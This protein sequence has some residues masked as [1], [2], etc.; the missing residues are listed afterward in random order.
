MTF[1][2]NKQILRVNLSRR[3][4]RIEKPSNFFYRRYF[5]GRAVIAYYLLK[6][7]RLGIDP[8]G[9]RNILVF[10][11]GVVTGA[12]IP[13]GGRNS[14]GAK[15]PLTGAY[16]EAEAGGFWGAELKHAGL[17]G[18]VIKGRAKSPVY[19]WI[20]D[21]EV[22]I[23][24]AQHLW[25]LDIGDSQEIIR[26]DAGERLART[27]QIGKGGE[28]MV[29]FACIINDLKHA[30]GRVGMGAVMG[31]KNLKAIAVRGHGGPE[32]ANVGKLKELTEWVINTLEEEHGGMHEYGTGAMMTQ[33]VLS[34]NLPTRNFRDGEFPNPEAIS[35]QTIKET[36]LIRMES[37]YFCPVRCKKVVK[38]EKPYVVDPIYGGPEYETLAAFGSNCGI[39]DLKAI[40]KA[41]ELCQ[42]F[43]LDT[44]STGSVIAFAMECFENKLLTKTDTD[45][46]DLTFGNAEAMLQMVE[47]IAKREG[48]GDLLAEGTM[49]AA[50]RIGKGAE[51]FAVHVKGEEPGMHDPRL[52]RGLGLGYAVKPTGADHMNILHD[53]WTRSLPSFGI[54]KPVPIE[55]LGWRKVRLYIYKVTFEIIKNCLLLCD[56]VHWDE[57]QIVEIVRAVTGWNSNLWEIMKV[58]ERSINM[59]RA[60]NI[61]EGFTRKDD[62]LPDRFFHPQT[63]GPLSDTAVDPKKLENAKSTYYSMMGWDQEKG[64]PTR[65]KLEELGIPWVADK[66]SL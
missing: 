56:F 23:R 3:K 66:L 53:T 19:L 49:R 61:R 9:P 1:G 34:G 59:A 25:G 2:Y 38:I 11:P 15:S 45:G 37:C 46:I 13:G 42:R 21:S 50:E 44:I 4:I 40:C 28:R 7:L 12:P 43:T 18:I 57:N 14:V 60:F 17:D 63:S 8:L 54:I 5:G 51:K 27:A 22:E 26:K 36:V 30:A 62:W 41:H 10:A 52:K 24:D 47:M 16:G 55:D 65:A 58:G 29:R 32:M 39:D 35:A 48:I 33:G 31:S 64:A 20:H 6:E